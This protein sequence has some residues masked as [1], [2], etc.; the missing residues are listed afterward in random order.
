MVEAVGVLKNVGNIDK[1]KLLEIEA[2]LKE[3]GF[4]K[5]SKISKNDKYRYAITSQVSRQGDARTT[6]YT[7]QWIE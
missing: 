4:D 2:Q 5:A 1:D 3:K 6:Q 7:I